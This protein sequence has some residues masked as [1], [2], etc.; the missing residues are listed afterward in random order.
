MR[1][2]LNDKVR[3]IAGNFKGLE[4]SV[5]RVIAEKNRVVVSGVN[6]RKKHQKPRPS[7]GRRAAPGGIIEFELPIDASNVML[8][9]P[10]TGQPTRIG[11]RRDEEGH[12]VRF[13][14]KS[15]KDLD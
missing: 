12:P 14:K 4:G 6:V 3:V 1:F 5:Q 2:K 9:C 13:S 8:I 10:T 11:I 7:G 15:G